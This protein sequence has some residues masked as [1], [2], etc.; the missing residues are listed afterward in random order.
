MRCRIVGDRGHLPQADN[1][2]AIQRNTLADKVPLDG[3]R[4]P[5]T[6]VGVVLIASNAVGKALQFDHVSAWALRYFEYNIVQQS[7]RWFAEFVG[8][9]FEQDCVLV[10][11][12]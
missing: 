6:Q 5:F 4:T 9:E 1:R 8:I 10:G 2:N 7:D 11:N 12:G 3:F